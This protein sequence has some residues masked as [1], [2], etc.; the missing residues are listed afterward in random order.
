MKFFFTFFVA[1]MISM[2]ITFSL[3]WFHASDTDTALVK[4]LVTKVETAVQKPA[5]QLGPTL[6][7]TTALSSDAAPA[8]TVTPI[9]SEQER[10]QTLEKRKMAL[11]QFLGATDVAIA[12]IKTDLDTARRNSAPAE[13]IARQEKKLNDIEMIRRQLLARNADI[14]PKG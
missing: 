8:L 7:S 6:A 14:D 10:E 1:L 5:A 3:Y 12:R 4:G 13:E 11:P 2:G 9:T